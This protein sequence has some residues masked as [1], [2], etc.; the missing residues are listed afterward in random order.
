MPD[1]RSYRVNFD[2]FKRLAPD[3][4]PEMDLRSAIKEL[5]NGLEQMGF[6]D[7]DFRNSDFIRLKVLTNLR[8]K[9]YLS[10]N[11]KWC[12][13]RSDGETGAQ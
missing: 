8:S 11:L 2:L 10:E 5:K 9:G 1:K 7:P 4:Q 6:N 12:R 3:H 13:D